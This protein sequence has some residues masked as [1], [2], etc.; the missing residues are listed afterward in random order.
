VE[1]QGTEQAELIDR[2]G[3]QDL[4]GHDQRD[5]GAD[6]DAR[7]QKRDGQNVEGNG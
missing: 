2:Q 3:S 5:R 4:A 1:D 6:P 7:R